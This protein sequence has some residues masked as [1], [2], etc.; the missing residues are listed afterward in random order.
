MFIVVVI[1]VCMLLGMFW[2]S[3]SRIVVFGF[4]VF[5]ESC[6]VWIFILVVF[7]NVL[8]LFSVF[9]WLM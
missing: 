6:V 2:F 8:I 4:L 3:C 9:G 5:L 7:S 1:V